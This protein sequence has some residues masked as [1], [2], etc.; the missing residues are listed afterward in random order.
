MQK[1]SYEKKVLLYSGGMDSWLIDKIWKPDVKLYVDMGTK[2]SQEEIK[3]LPA[4]VVVEKLD[5]SKW[6]REDKIIPLRNMY[7]IG[8]ATNYGNEIC[9]G[10]TAGDRVLDKSPIFADMYEQLLNYLYRKQHWTEERKIRINLDFK[11]YTKAQLVWIY[12]E[13][14]GNIENAF[15]SSFSCYSPEDG[16]ECWKCKPCFRKFIAFALNGYP[17]T[18]DIIDR[19]VAYI[20]KEILPLI[21][22]GIYGRKQEEDEIMKV[23]TIYK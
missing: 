4:D 15:A 22:S 16:K 19:N 18:E 5:L 17:F 13:Q 6:E 2:Y 11:K 21:E 23:L 10:A 20:K 3:R 12:K 7:L 14:G 1:S 8:I 9:L